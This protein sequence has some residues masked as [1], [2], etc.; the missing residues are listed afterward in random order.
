MMKKTFAIIA[1]V[2]FALPLFASNAK[3]HADA[4]RLAAILVDA[5]DASVTGAAMTAASHEAYSLALHIFT[6]A[7]TKAARDAR[8]HVKQMRAAADAGDAAGARDHASQALPFV[9][10]V[11]TAAAPK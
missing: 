9:Y 1:L 7:G 3:V 11:I 5:Q 6:A 4:T 8:A 10:E 2:L